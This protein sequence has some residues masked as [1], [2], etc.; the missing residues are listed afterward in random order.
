[1]MLVERFLGS[2]LTSLSCLVEAA[3]L[4]IIQWKFSA[5]GGFRKVQIPVSRSHGLLE[6]SSSVS[7]VR[8]L[9]LFLTEIALFLWDDSDVGI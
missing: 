2:L 8:N 4:I 6:V 3:S 1:M 9:L 7:A 5:P